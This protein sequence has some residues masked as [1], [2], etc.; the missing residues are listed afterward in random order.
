M[1]C[2]TQLVWFHVHVCHHGL[3][4]VW[5]L[6]YSK[7]MNMISVKTLK[8]YFHCLCCYNMRE[9]LE[10][11]TAYETVFATSENVFCTS[12]LEKCGEW[13]VMGQVIQGLS[14]WLGR[15]FIN[16]ECRKKWKNKIL[17]SGCLFSKIANGSHKSGILRLGG[18]GLFSKTANFFSIIANGGGWHGSLWL[19]ENDAK[20]L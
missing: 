19:V 4:N 18:G 16:R 3:D 10:H 17:R 6:N 8:G 7:A 5:A 12:H 15:L 20:G 9:H 13:M 2:A 1:P 14:K 11:F